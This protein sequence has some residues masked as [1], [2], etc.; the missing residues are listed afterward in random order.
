MDSKLNGDVTGTTILLV[1]RGFVGGEA[2]YDAAFLLT[3]NEDAG[4]LRSARIENGEI[5][6]RLSNRSTGGTIKKFVH[7]DA[8]S[9]TLKER[10]GK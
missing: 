4:N 8:S 1:R 9:G 10:I 7:Y 6:L 3:P 5:A 2:G